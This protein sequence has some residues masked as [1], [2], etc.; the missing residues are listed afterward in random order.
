MTNP[1]KY[2]DVLTKIMV[3]RAR[4]IFTAEMRISGRHTVPQKGKKR[5]AEQHIQFLN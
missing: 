1:N 4:K 2:I 5:A 3:S